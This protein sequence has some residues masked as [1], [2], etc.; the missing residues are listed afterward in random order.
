MAQTS[1]EKSDENRGPPLTQDS[2]S[3]LTFNILA[4]IYK[5]VEDEN[6]ARNLNAWRSRHEAIAHFLSSL[7]QPKRPLPPPGPRNDNDV[8][9]I[10]TAETAHA[11]DWAEDDMLCVC[12]QEF[13]CDERFI[14]LYKDS[15]GDRYVVLIIVLFYV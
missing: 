3:I 14:K 12:L 2:F 5:Q 15:F 10:L 6:E 13:W 1:D 9:N 4:P 7:T 11:H 8:S